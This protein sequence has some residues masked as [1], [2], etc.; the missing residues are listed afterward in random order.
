MAWEK[1]GVTTGGNQQEFRC[2]STDTK[3]TEDIGG[4]SIVRELD[5]GKVYE[6]SEQNINPATSNGW[7][8]V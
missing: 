4:G 8:E 6:F 2:L 1:V 3:K 5:T 7:W